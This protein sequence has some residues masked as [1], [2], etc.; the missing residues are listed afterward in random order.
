MLCP[1]PEPPRYLV[2][3]PPF[4]ENIDFTLGLCVFEYTSW[5]VFDCSF[6]SEY[7]WPNPEILCQELGPQIYQAHLCTELAFPNR[8]DPRPGGKN[9]M[10]ITGHGRFEGPAPDT[11]Y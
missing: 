5:I 3:V 2:H 10:Y 1:G 6:L 8:G 9:A 11:A 7:M 4:S